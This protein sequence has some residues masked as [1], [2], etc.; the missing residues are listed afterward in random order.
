MCVCVCVLLYLRGLFCFPGLRETLS[1]DWL[2]PADAGWFLEYKDFGNLPMVVIVI[3]HIEQDPTATVVVPTVDQKI[4]ST[5][6]LNL[7]YPLDSNV[8]LHLFTVCVRGI[9]PLKTPR[10]V[11]KLEKFSRV[12]F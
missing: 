7:R 11:Q 5:H 3:I 9:V 2:G 6:K 12:F 4:K 8:L 1:S 10:K